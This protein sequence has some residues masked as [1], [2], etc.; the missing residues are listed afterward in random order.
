MTDPWW[1]RDRLALLAQLEAEQRVPV[2]PPPRVH[3]DEHTV[4]VRLVGNITPLIAQRMIRA[5]RHRA[6]VVNPYGL[7]YMSDVR[8]ARAERAARRAAST[9]IVDGGPIE[10]RHAA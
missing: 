6:A 2:S 10:R 5:S 7:N 9:A 8:R 3:P 4:R 1:E